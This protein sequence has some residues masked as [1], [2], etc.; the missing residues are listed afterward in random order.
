MEI[1]RLFGS[2]FVDNDAANRSLSDT[3]RRGQGLA[4]TFETMGGKLKAFGG[5]MSTAV[6]APLVG[7]F[8]AITQG[9]KELRGDL[10]VLS[11]N[12]QVAGQDMGILNEAMIKLHAVTG[13]TDSNVEGLS[14]LL[15]TGFRD[16]QLSTLLDSLYGASIKFKDTM[17][18]E[19]IADGLQETLATGAAIGPFGELLERSGVAL[20]GFNQG[21]QTAIANGTQEQYVL[22]VLA[23]TGLAG[24]Y[25][26]YRKNNQAMVEAEEANFRMQQSMAKLGATL[27]PILTPIISKV[28]ELISKFNDM[29]PA[30]QK[31][32]FI[33]GGIVMAIGP[34]L[35][36]LGLLSSGIGTAITLV[37]TITAALPTMGAALAVITGPIGL[38]IAAIAALVAIGV[39]LYK[40]WG[41]IAAFGAKIWSDIKN[42]WEPNMKALGDGWNTFTEMIS[43][44]WSVMWGSVTTVFNTVQNYLDTATDTLTTGM[45]VKWTTFKTGITQIWGGITGAIKGF[46]NDQLRFVNKLIDALNSIHVEIPEW[47][48]GFG[49]ESFGIDLP[50]VPY[51][52]QGGDITRRGWAV[53]GEQGPELLDLNAGAQ[54]RPLDKASGN[55]T[56]ERGAFEGAFIMDDYGVD[57]LMDRIFARMGVKGG[58]V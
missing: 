23:K 38:T 48:P 5:T 53:V 10:S 25:E 47:V 32:I 4:N 28:T 18:F 54:V 45:L 17:K 56:F 40:N 24:T 39:L 16:E 52:A 44:A 31:T 15:A 6:T 21:L 46:I 57:R 26:A 13:E 12:A 35:L 19:G 51:L 33:I 9:T 55:V 8:L 41:E 1:F 3:D 2:V 43:E 14:E 27:E 30:G 36:G 7:G 37:G 42:A 34:L 49:G 50:Q 22:D 58:V 20:D 29:E 11:T